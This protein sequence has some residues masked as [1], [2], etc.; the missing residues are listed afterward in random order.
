MKL[1]DRN[2]QNSTK[3]DE[4]MRNVIVYKW[5][6]YIPEE[7]RTEKIAVGTGKFHQFGCS[8][9]EFESG[10]GNYST[11]IIEREDGTVENVVPELI[12]FTS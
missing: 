4:I 7:R 6:K 3:G 8:Y 9:E 2:K 10:A 12:R 11:A 1:S 5:G